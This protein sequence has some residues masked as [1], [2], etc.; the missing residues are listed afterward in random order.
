[1]F[2]TS[3]GEGVTTEGMAG[4]V[5]CVSFEMCLALLLFTCSDKIP[6]PLSFRLAEA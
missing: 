3:E 5:L 4:H 2:V 1:M 6:V